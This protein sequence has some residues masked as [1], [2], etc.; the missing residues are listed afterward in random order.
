MTFPIYGKKTM[1]Q[2]TNQTCLG[3]FWALACF[4]SAKPRV[5]GMI[6]NCLTVCGLTHGIVTKQ[7][8]NRSC[9]KEHLFFLPKALGLSV[10]C[11]VHFH[12][13][14]SLSLPWASSSQPWRLVA[15]LLAKDFNVNKG[16]M[17]FNL[18]RFQLL[19][20]GG[21]VSWTQSHVVLLSSSAGII[22]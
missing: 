15:R 9:Q 13:A 19:V 17:D 12:F 4:E 14:Q 18:L 8:K 20:P 16:L 10:I 3:L 21:Y 2:T 22:P 1:F 11:F 5:F 7:L 6:W